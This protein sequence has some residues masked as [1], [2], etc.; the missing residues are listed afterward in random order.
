MEYVRGWKSRAATNIF[1]VYNNKLYLYPELLGDDDY[2]HASVSKQNF[3]V[4]F[5]YTF[6]D[7]HGKSTTTE[8]IG[9][10]NE[11]TNNSKVSTVQWKTFDSKNGK[12]SCVTGDTLVTMADGSYKRIDEVTYSDQLLVWDFY[13]GEYACVPAA[14]I[15]R[16]GYDNNT[17]IKLG[18]EDGTEV[19]AVNLHQ[20]F[21]AELN[22]LVTIDADSVSQY[23]NHS[24]VKR[25]G[26]GYKTVKLTDYEISEQYVEAFGIVSAVHYNI[27]VEDMFS[28]DYPY[29]LYDLMTYFEV[30]ENLVYDKAKMEKDIEIYGLYTYDEFADYMTLEQ[31]EA[32][33]IKYMKISVGKGYYTYE[34]IL[35]LIEEY[36]K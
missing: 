11:M 31:F 4:A 6:T 23:V 15:S 16:H 29:E 7:P 32:M 1:N 35:A 12:S 26:N 20:F 8:T 18:F 5:K 17:V 3:D 10:Y 13:N 36:L 14:I 30:G 22:K 25:D 19:K 21:D 2:V 27:L 28:A 33:N 34:G 9:W 24:F